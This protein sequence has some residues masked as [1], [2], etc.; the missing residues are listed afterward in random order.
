MASSE[1]QTESDNWRDNWA[2]ENCLV[3][4][5]I[6]GGFFRTSDVKHALYHAGKSS[7]MLF[8][9][10][11]IM[12]ANPMQNHMDDSMELK[13]AKMA[14]TMA[15]GMTSG[16]IAFNMVFSVIKFLAGCFKSGDSGL[17]EK[18]LPAKNSV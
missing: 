3:P 14:V 11:G 16:V 18:L 1:K 8:G 13:F 2:V 10:T 12:L 5:P 4:L 17:D 9:G 6:V 15:I 7:A